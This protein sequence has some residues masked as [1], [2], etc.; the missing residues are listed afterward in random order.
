LFIIIVICRVVCVAEAMNF[1]LR[2][3]RGRNYIIGQ[4]KAKVMK[5]TQG[6]YPAPLKII[7]VGYSL[8]TNLDSHF[9]GNTNLV[10]YLVLGLPHQARVK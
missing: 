6:V 9:K 5:Q 4:V 2:Y 8:A 7:D 10:P 3:D 1:A